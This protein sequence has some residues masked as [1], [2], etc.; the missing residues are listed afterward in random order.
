VL[1]RNLRL[2]QTKIEKGREGKRRL[3]ELIFYLPPQYII[4]KERERE[5]KG[6]EIKK[7]STQTS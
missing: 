2:L 1:G 3:T 6:E 4:L 5:R 7:T